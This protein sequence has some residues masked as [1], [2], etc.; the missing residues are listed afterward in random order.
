MRLAFILLIV[1]GWTTTAFANEAASAPSL[2]LEQAIQLV[3]DNNPRLKAAEY[4]E[5]AAAAKIRQSEST[6]PY[7]MNLTVENFAGTG[8]AGGADLME[9]TL[10]LSQVLEL[11]GK[12]TGRSE[13]AQEEANL[14]SDERGI[15]RLDLLA[16]TARRFVHVAAD[17]ERLAIARDAVVLAEQTQNFIKRRV[18]AGKSPAAESRRAGISVYRNQLDLEHAEHGMESARL[19]L[20]ILW[21]ESRPSWG[22]AVANLFELGQV[23]EFE[24]YEGLLDRNPDLVRFATTQRLAEAR[25]RLARSRGRPDVELSGG[26]RFLNESA[27]ATL[28]LT[29]SF[30]FGSSRRAAPFMDEADMLNRREPLIFEERRLSLQAAL[31]EMVQ[32]LR[33]TEAQIKMLRERIIPEAERV[34]QDYEEGYGAG[35]FSYLELIDAQRLL[36]S[37]RLELVTAAA[38]FHLYRIEIDRLTGATK[39]EGAAP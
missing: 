8:D 37:S 10:S 26:V 18:D 15:E 14:Q 39:T 29:A 16:E 12:R 23:E 36:L 21:G 24:S 33:H 22:T 34:L 17:Q 9:T 30:P 4:E 3:I 1:G 25:G 31:F 5:R 27:D 35:R 11:G 6:P 13:V 2:T 7:R 19:G 28:V 38:D 20:S 32:E